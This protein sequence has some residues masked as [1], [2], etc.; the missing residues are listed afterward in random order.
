M[1][2]FFFFN[3]KA[4]WR[5]VSIW[6]FILLTEQV[7]AVTLGSKAAAGIET[8]KREVESPSCAQTDELGASE[9]TCAG[10]LLGSRG[11]G[12]GHAHSH[13]ASSWAAR[14]CNLSLLSLPW[15]TCVLLCAMGNRERDGHNFMW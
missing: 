8:Y 15:V 10:F 7:E 4:I 13:P 5:R 3:T 9:P 11:W 14:N 1:T 6:I 2:F 12:E